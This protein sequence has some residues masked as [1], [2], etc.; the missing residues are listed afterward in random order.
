[1]DALTG[2]AGGQNEAVCR[3]WVGPH[4]SMGAERCVVPRDRM[5]RIRNLAAATCVFLMACFAQPQS[6]PTATVTAGAETGIR[7]LALPSI[8]PGAPC[9]RSPSRPHEQ[10]DPSYQGT[11]DALGD[12]PVYPVID[13]WPD[14]STRYGYGG[15]D[16]HGWH[17]I[18]M[19]WTTRPGYD[20]RVL[21]RGRRLN[22]NNQLRFGDG[23]EPATEFSWI[24]GGVEDVWHHKGGLLRLR[25]PGCY[26]MQIDGPTFSSVIVFSASPSWV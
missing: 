11:G 15:A 6:S 3:N 25:Q 23:L 22:G 16:Q 18:K 14:G 19:G 20:G 2:T 8:G 24:V 4:C 1:M 21:V 5:S 13:V 9:P 7:P 17:F 12:G 10:V 26:G